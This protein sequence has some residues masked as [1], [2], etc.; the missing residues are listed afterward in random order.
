M[1]LNSVKVSK[2]L[3]TLIKNE[4]KKEQANEV[5]NYYIDKI[6]SGY[7]YEQ[8]KKND[9]INATESALLFE[10]AS[11]RLA[12]SRKFVNWQNLWVDSY[13]ARY[14]TPEIIAKY[15]IKRFENY[16]V[17][18]LGA[19]SGI[20]DLI[21]SSSGID[22]IGIEKDPVRYRFCLLNLQEYPESHVKFVH[23]D[24]YD[25]D[26]AD[27]IGEDDVIFSDPSRPERE[28]ER[29]LDSLLPSPLSIYE[30]FKVTTSNFAFDLPPQIRRDRISI[31]GET[32]YISI[33]GNLNRLTLYTGEL[34]KNESSAVMLPS[35]KMIYGIPKPYLEKNGKIGS[36]ILV[37]DISASYAGLLWKVAELYPITFLTL[38]RRRVMFSSDQPVDD[39]FGEQYEVVEVFNDLFDPEVYKKHDVSKVYPRYE[40]EE[41][42][43]YNVK[44]KI[45]KNLS[46][47]R[48]AYI[49]R[50][51]ERYALAFK[52]HTN[53]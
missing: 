32:E 18:D 8:L 22:V 34:A 5:V 44:N 49:F 38:D 17:L 21:F 47:E 52:L 51:D 27:A 14:T 1:Q 40:I 26:P 42:E 19:G 24:A 37:P 46:G 7:S 36:Y 43:Y 12:I 2:Y 15:R 23:S 25:L 3:D 31:G 53:P 35:G 16:K 6:R 9:H 45:E 41:S 4:A 50:I 48:S 39:F 10:I 13:L 29:F 33:N 11:S 20:Q 30:T 28:P